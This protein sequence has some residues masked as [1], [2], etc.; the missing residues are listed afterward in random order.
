MKKTVSFLLLICLLCSVFSVCS[1]AGENSGWYTTAEIDGKTVNLI[2]NEYYEKYYDRLFET[3]FAAYSYDTKIYEE[4]DKSQLPQG[5]DITSLD[6]IFTDIIHGFFGSEE[7][8]K[9]GASL[10]SEMTDSQETF[11]LIVFLNYDE[12]FSAEK[13]REMLETISDIDEI[14]YIG[15]TTPCA[16]V[17]VTGKNIDSLLNSDA[18]KFV[19]YA[20]AALGYQPYTRI[21]EDGNR[22]FEPNAS[23]A[24]KILR[25]AAGLYDLSD[26]IYQSEVKEFFILSDTDLNGKITA[27]DARNAL[28][29][30]AG[31]EKGK[32]YT[33]SSESFWGY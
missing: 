16:V 26:M 22:T 33:V 4:I 31:L 25:Y 20:F 19:N 1:Y 17:T 27:A 2:R 10:Y 14:I 29:I 28:R 3:A 30:S 11:D 18:V 6:K 8:G 7:I 13:N 23:D 5:D 12:N 21:P 32:T 15:S 24:R 9:I